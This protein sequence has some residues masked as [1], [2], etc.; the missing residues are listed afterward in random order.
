MVRPFGL[1][2]FLTTASA[3]RLQSWRRR[4]KCSVGPRSYSPMRWSHCHSPC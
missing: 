4:S 3:E 1:A 2:R